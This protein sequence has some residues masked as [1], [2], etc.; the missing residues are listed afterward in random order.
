MHFL[1]SVLSS[2]GRPLKYERPGRAAGPRTQYKSIYFW[3]W[4]AHILFSRYDFM[5]VFWVWA[6][7]FAI[8]GSIKACFHI[9]LAVYV[10]GLPVGAH[11]ASYRLA[12]KQHQNQTVVTVFVFQKLTAPS[13]SKNQKS[14]FTALLKAIFKGKR[15]NQIG[16]PILTLLSESQLN[17]NNTVGS[18]T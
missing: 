10:N 18:F 3:R 16:K 2:T 15:P 4:A 5:Y 1:N 11:I 13:N 8:G 17:K 7:R 9:L 12:S 14:I 6:R